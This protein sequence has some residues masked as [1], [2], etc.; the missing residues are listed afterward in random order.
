MHT[1]GGF[2]NK[3]KNKCLQIYDL[4]AIM[5]KTKGAGNM[6]GILRMNLDEQTAKEYAY[7][8]VVEAGGFVFLTFCVGNIG[9]NV[10]MQV[11]G[12]LDNMEERLKACAEYISKKYGKE[13][14]EILFHENPTKILNNESI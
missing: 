9:Q 11:H 2:F 5:E 14:A 8:E 1:Q 13:Y 7:S 4:C 6:S 3:D 12:A 10:E